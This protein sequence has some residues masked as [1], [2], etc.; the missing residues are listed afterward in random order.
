VPVI[1]EGGGVVT[2][3]GDVHYVVTEYGIARAPFGDTLRNWGRAVPA[4][5]GSNAA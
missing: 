5:I 4:A 2:S 1:T 3:R